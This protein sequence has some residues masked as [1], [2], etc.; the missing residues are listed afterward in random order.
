[1]TAA[2]MDPSTGKPFCVLVAGPDCCSAK[3][4]V[5]WLEYNAFILDINP[6]MGFDTHRCEVE[7]VAVDVVDG[8]EVLLNTDNQG[9]ARDY[10][11]HAAE[12]VG[13]LAIFDVTARQSMADMYTIVAHTQEL[14]RARGLAPLPFAVIGTDLEEDS[15][16][17]V[18]PE[19]AR[20]IAAARGALS[21]AA[22]NARTGEHVRAAF[23][24]AIMLLIATAHPALNDNRP[25]RRRP[26]QHGVTHGCRHQ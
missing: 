8:P 9:F 18:P 4:A 23:T 15:V 16:C 21:Y 20:A 1:M 14:R 6:P 25:V 2:R 19:D 12:A 10:E 24:D 5:L 3:C 17:A 22:V 13:L 7:G 11:A 26:T